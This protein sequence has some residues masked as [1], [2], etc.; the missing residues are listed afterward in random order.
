MFCGLWGRCH[1]LGVCAC[2]LCSLACFFFAAFFVILSLYAGK[3]CLW[4]PVWRTVLGFPRDHIALSYTLWWTERA[5]G[6]QSIKGCGRCSLWAWVVHLPASLYYAF[7][8]KHTPGEHL[9]SRSRFA[10]GDYGSLQSHKTHLTWHRPPWGCVCEMGDRWGCWLAIQAASVA[11]WLLSQYLTW[12]YTS[13][14]RFP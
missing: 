12:E 2:L 6:A 11:A 10:A 8:H 13:Y 14:V 9:S 7:V 1:C 4:V 5:M 3:C